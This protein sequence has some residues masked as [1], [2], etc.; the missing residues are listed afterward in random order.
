MMV[1]P[2][3]KSKRQ[4]KKANH[5]KGEDEIAQVLAASIVKLSSN[6]ENSQECKI[7]GYQVSEIPG[8]IAET[9]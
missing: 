3:V 5:L 9:E 6:L 2:K 1:F 8:V 4:A 7:A